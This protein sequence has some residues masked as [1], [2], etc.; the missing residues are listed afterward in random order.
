[1]QAVV[2]ILIVAAGAAL[3]YAAYTDRVGAL[4]VLWT[5]GKKG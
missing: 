2:G 3:L 5:P 4:S 1:M